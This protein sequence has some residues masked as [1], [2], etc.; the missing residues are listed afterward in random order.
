MNEGPLKI[1]QLKVSMKFEKKESLR[2]LKKYISG[3]LFIRMRGA[4]RYNYAYVQHSFN[5]SS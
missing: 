2:P 1:R 4:F 3:L 5:V